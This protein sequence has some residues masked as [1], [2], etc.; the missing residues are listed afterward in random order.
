MKQMLIVVMVVAT[1]LISGSPAG[2]AEAPTG[3]VFDP[4]IGISGTAQFDLPDDGYGV[5]ASAFDQSGLLY[6]IG[7]PDFGTSP[8]LDRVWRLFPD[9][10]LDTSWAANGRLDLE[11]PIGDT[12][13]RALTVDDLGRL[14][15][16]RNETVELRRTY[17]FTPDGSVDPS[18][19]PVSWEF[20]GM[21]FDAGPAEMVADGEGV[22]VAHTTGAGQ[23][24]FYRIDNAGNVDM[25]KVDAGEGTWS[26]IGVTASGYVGG[27]V[28]IDQGGRFP[29]LWH[30]AAPTSPVFVEARRGVVTSLNDTPQG[31]VAVGIFDRA[32]TADG[33][34]GFSVELPTTT[35]PWF[36]GEGQLVETENL[37][38]SLAPV[39]VFAD[40]SVAGHTGRFY[41]D[42]FVGQV[43]GSGSIE[44]RPER[45]S[46][47]DPFWPVAAVTT[48]DGRRFVTGRGGEGQPPIRV[49]A[50]TPEL[51]PA[52]SGD[53]LNDQIFRLYEAYYLRT[54]DPGGEAFWREQRASGRSLQAISAQ[55]A[56]APEFIELYGQLSDAAFVE[57]IYT[58][59]LQR[60]GDTD[61]QTFWT[62]QL[63][64]R[65]RTRGSVMLEFS[66]S[67]ENVERTNTV[68]PHDDPTG[69][70]YR[71]YNAY[72]DRAPDAG[73]S[74][75]WVRRMVGGLPLNDV[76]DSFAAS[77][78]F[79]DTYGS[80]TNRAFVELVYTNVLGREGEISG[81]RF[82]TNELD[83][84][85]RTRG[86][87]MAG[88]SES[89]EHIERTGTLPI[90]S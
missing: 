2:G 88:F 36:N 13:A 34:S 47:G 3:C 49:M 45:I 12:H 21:R 53:A 44:L 40:R 42:F 52:A 84:A 81:V 14:W 1:S 50:L 18:M 46:A 27:E 20:G 8:A 73:G 64:T 11:A 17:R 86:E 77:E 65:S 7:D 74:C 55:F 69:S 33:P 39:A 58:N 10:T 22:V 6:V 16:G 24:G 31:T 19:T 60:P 28:S 9:G 41:E 85:R 72:F 59:V 82:W 80:L 29:F 56:G 70:V 78:E 87:V 54:P 79:I 62:G 51:G 57:L 23:L 37:D 15:V 5:R 76:S 25:S 68:A 32:T 89:P 61:G 71:L 63:T 26:A 4:A 75:F 38:G 83:E 35:P 30:A 66:E 67:D 90:A 48:D 43:T